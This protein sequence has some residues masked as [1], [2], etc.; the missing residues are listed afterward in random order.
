MLYTKKELQTEVLK[1]CAY[2]LDEIHMLNKN[3]AISEYDFNRMITLLL[4]YKK[5]QQNSTRDML[6]TIITALRV[7]NYEIVT[8]RSEHNI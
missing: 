7:I 4:K 1:R 2:H 6:E 3:N 8:L 5:M